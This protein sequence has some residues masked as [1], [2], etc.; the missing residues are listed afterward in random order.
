MTRYSTMQA[1][2]SKAKRPQ[3]PE[4]PAV[5]DPPSTDEER[6]RA[7]RVVAYQRSQ[8]RGF[9]PGY[10]LEDWLAA[11]QEVDAATEQVRA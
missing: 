3:A 9:E 2:T 6:M 4:T 8:A 7:I 10:E 1:K 11:E 5:D